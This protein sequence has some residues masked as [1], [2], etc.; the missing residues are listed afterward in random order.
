MPKNLNSKAVLIVLS[1]CLQI[2]AQTFP[3]TSNGHGSMPERSVYGPD[4]ISPQHIPN[5]TPY[6][7]R[8]PNAEVFKTL[9]LQAEEVP[10]RKV[11]DRYYNVKALGDF[12]IWVASLPPTEE[13]KQ[14]LNLSTRPLPNWSLLYGRIGQITDRNGILLWR[15]DDSHL[16]GKP[17]LVRIRNL[18]STRNLVDGE[19]LAVFARNEDP[20]VYIDTERTKVTVASYDYGQVVSNKEMQ[21]YLKKLSNPAPKKPKT[22]TN[23]TNSPK[24]P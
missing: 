22:T 8:S 4:Q 18:P 24:I 23:V 7:E 11:D 14:A 13:S 16:I 17:T 10:F 3:P 15:Y 1:F 19:V 21:E 20:Y 12:L 6:L 5:A 9:V 2:H